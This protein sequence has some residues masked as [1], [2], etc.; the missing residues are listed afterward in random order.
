MIKHF[1]F[2]LDG[3]I[4]KSR[5]PITE[6]MAD[7]LLKLTAKGADVII[8]SGAEKERIYTQVGR[9]IEEVFVMA[10]NGNNTYESSGRKLWD[11][12]LNW[13][14]KY[15]ILNL[16]EFFQRIK[17]G[18][19][20]DDI[21]LVED[22]GSQISFS[23]VGHNAPLDVKKEWD[24]SGDKRKE[25]LNDS[26]FEIWLDDIKE[27]GVN[28]AIGGTTCIDFYISNKG[29]NIDKLIKEMN[30]EK[31]EC[32]YVGDALFKGGND[33]TVVGVIETI[34]VK[35]DI[36]CESIV[37]KFIKEYVGQLVEIEEEEDELGN[38]MD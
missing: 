30:W 33:E 24:P 35:D 26:M 8:V 2:D 11:N 6:E 28:W 17:V 12:K 21:D 22:R 10:Q 18:T 25:I 34:K 27:S 29:E 16:C 38:I 37:K 36:E 5:S 1:F 20:S 32:V 3:T 23:F 13:I 9:V 7:L 15:N 4:T 14:Q 19:D 31:G